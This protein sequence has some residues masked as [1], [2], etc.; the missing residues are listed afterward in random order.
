MYMCVCVC[1][2]VVSSQ[3]LDAASG[4][5]NPKP[6]YSPCVC[7]LSVSDWTQRLVHLTQSP[8]IAHVC[9][10]CQ[11][12][13]VSAFVALVMCVCVFWITAFISLYSLCMF[14]L[15]IAFLS[16][17]CVVNL[18]GWPLVR[19]L[20]KG[21]VFYVL[22]WE[23]M[24]SPVRCYVTGGLSPVKCF[25]IGGFVSGEV[26]CHW[27]FVSGEVLCHWGFVSGEVLCHGGFVSGEVLCHG[28][29]VSGEV[30]CHGGLSLVRC[31]VIGGL[32][33]VRCYVTGGFTVLRD[34]YFELIVYCFFFLSSD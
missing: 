13:L 20:L 4:A 18:C 22:V 31:Y 29:F 21:G 32:S 1:V 30:L 12:S 33:P 34:E 16:P 24:W 2:C 10:C 5:V 23:E 7:V 9:V 3:W 25:V 19:G 11:Q 26:L 15:V 17:V 14:L 6:Q 8:C 28:G 27:G